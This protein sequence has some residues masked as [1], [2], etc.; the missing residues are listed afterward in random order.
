MAVVPSLPHLRSIVEL[1][2]SRTPPEESS[3]SLVIGVYSG[4]A[5]RDDSLTLGGETYRIVHA[6]SVLQVREAL[7][8]AH[9]IPHTT[10]VLKHRTH[11]HL[12]QSILSWRAPALSLVTRNNSSC[13]CNARQWIRSR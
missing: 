8:E 5:A 12:I 9:I 7:L 2:R 13:L 11:A 6:P 4:R 1:V 3:A 10:S